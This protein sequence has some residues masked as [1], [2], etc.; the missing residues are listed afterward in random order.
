MPL[1][2]ATHQVP[3]EMILYFERVKKPRLHGTSTAQL[4]CELCT[5]DGFIRRE[6]VQLECPIPRSWIDHCSKSV[7][8][9]P[10]AQDVEQ[11]RSN[12]TGSFPLVLLANEQGR[13][14]LARVAMNFPGGKKGAMLVPW[15]LIA[16]ASRGEPLNFASGRKCSPAVKEASSTKA[17]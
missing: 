8:Q 14:T 11:P 5:D 4:S 10:H 7:G 16:N 2:F 13:Q 12:A 17:Q 15:R 9:S 6:H 1:Y 3:M